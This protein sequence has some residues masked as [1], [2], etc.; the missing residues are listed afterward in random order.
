[1]SDDHQKDR[2]RLDPDKFPK[3]LEL[4]LPPEVLDRLQ[5]V[6]T[7]SGRS[8]NEL[9]LEVLDQYLQDPPPDFQK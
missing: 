9:I 3:Q 8:V 4:D 5:E 6:A 2:Y 7:R 1:M